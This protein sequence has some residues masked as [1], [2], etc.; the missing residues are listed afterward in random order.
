MCRQLVQSREA[1]IARGRTT[2][3]V[4]VRPP[5]A[6]STSNLSAAPPKKSRPSQTR[7]FIPFC[8]PN[9]PVTTSLRSSIAF[10]TFCLT[11]TFQ[12]LDKPWSQ[13]SSLP[14]GYVPSVYIAH[15]AQHSHCSSISSNVANSSSRVF[16]ESICAQ[17]KVYEF[18]P[19]TMETR[20]SKVIFPNYF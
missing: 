9:K 6:L 18:I 17:E 20:C 12:L 4:A 13:V 15:R 11:S 7:F 10:L 2:G 19:M 1:A 3:A 5:K 16:Y 8:L 14:P